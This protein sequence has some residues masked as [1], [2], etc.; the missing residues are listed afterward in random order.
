M[1]T[2]QYSNL[3]Q[4]KSAVIIG[5]T[6]GIGLAVA[7]AVLEH[8]GSVVVASSSQ[9]KVKDAVQR[10]SD[11]ATTFNGDKSRVQGFTVNLTGPGSEASLSTLF[12]QIGQPFDHLVYT[13]GVFGGTSTKLEDITLET[14][15]KAPEVRLFGAILAVK[16]AVYG[17][18]LK[19][20]G[21]V[22]LTTGSL[23][24]YPIPGMAIQTGFAGAFTHLVRGLALDLSA[25]EIRVNAVSPG[26]VDT[27]LW[28]KIPPA[29]QEA[30]TS[31][32]LIQRAATPAE[33]ARA[34]LH[35]LTSGVITGETISTDNGGYAKK[36]DA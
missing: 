1:A 22:T 15:T 36:L 33:T 14:L 8:G 35:L 24:R 12:Q 9:D 28:A 20:G 2:A 26:P 27:E 7:Q 31:K 3:L 17:G 34:Y 18:F 5:G 21:S 10:L 6:S 13:A 25:K 23:H 29:L 16:T 11:P 4:G 30:F 32:L 19:T